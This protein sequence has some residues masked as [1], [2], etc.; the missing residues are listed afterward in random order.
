[1]AVLGAIAGAVGSAAIGAWSAK[2]AAD[3]QSD[4]ADAQFDVA[5][6][7]LKKKKKWLN[8]WR[9]AGGNALAMM[10]YDMGM[11]PDAPMIGYGQDKVEYGGWQQTPGYDFRMQEGQR[12]LEAGIANR[13]GY[14]SGAAMKAL[15]RYGQDYGTAEYENNLNR[16]FQMSNVGMNA[17]NQ[18]GAAAGQAGMMQSNALANQGN[19]QSAGWMGV[20]N[21]IQGGINNGLG[22]WAYGQDRGLW[23]GGLWDG[24]SGG[25]GAPMSSLRP[26]ARP[27]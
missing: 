2:K 24:G 1:M 23:D 4:A 17:A 6:T 14:N 12:A 26:Q 18:T 19:A 8:P 13:Q 9:K 5:N 11:R 21:A 27:Y 3:A 10:E 22:V 16:L 7:T 20:G 25:G 15:T